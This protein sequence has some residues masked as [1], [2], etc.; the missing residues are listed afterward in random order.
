[1]SL[2]TE[3]RPWTIEEL[4]REKGGNRIDVEDALADLEAHGL[5]TRINRRVVCASRAAIHSDRLSV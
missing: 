4:I 3:D 5:L 1:M 2:I